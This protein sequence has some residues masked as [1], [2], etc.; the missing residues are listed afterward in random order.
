MGKIKQF[1][2]SPQN[3]PQIKAVVVGLGLLIATF[4]ATLLTGWL[5][6]RKIAS[7]E[8]R[9]PLIF[10]AIKNDI[11]IAESGDDI[12]SWQ[13]VGPNEQSVCD[14]TLFDNFLGVGKTFE[15]GQQVRLEYGRDFGKHYCFRAVNSEGVPGYGPHHVQELER[16]SIG[17]TQTASKLKARL[18]R[19]SADQGF[20]ES[21]W[22]HVVLEDAS[23]SCA[24]AAFA[25]ESQ[26]IAGATAELLA[27]NRELHYCFR[28]RKINS[29][30]Y[31]AKSVFGAPSQPA[32]IKSLRSGDNLYL[33]ADQPIKN[34]AVAV[35]DGSKQCGESYFSDQ[36]A[37]LSGYQVAIIHLHLEHKQAE[38]Y[39]V[40]AQNENGLFSYQT[41]LH[42]AGLA[43]E[44][45]PSLDAASDGLRLEASSESAVSSWQIIAVDSVSDCAPAAF[46]NQEQI[47]ARVSTLALNYP[48]DR[49]LVYCWQARQGQLT[50]YATYEIPIGTLMIVAKQELQ[51]IRAEALLRPL[52]DWHYVRRE[53]ATTTDASQHCSADDFGGEIFAGQSARLETDYLYCFRAEDGSGKTHYGIWQ[54][55]SQTS[56]EPQH[57]EISVILANDLKLTRLGQSILREARP[58]VHDNLDSLKRACPP[59]NRFSCYASDGRLHLLKAAQLDEEQ[60]GE[61]RQSL[62]R[63][64]RWN[65]LSAEQR[66][67]QNFELLLLYDSQ[68]AAFDSILPANFYLHRIYQSEFI[69]DF[70]D[71][72]LSQPNSWREFGGTDWRNYYLLFFRE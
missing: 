55:A 20:D 41:Y 70:H 15:E 19:D 11:L 64:V 33:L 34:W 8:A 69:G 21:S 12:K 39:C 35:L 4:S 54:A 14:Q 63:I 26:I 31:Q 27:A 3:R 72:L 7:Q 9:P 46:G 17:F 71:F 23:V 61:L 25:D 45:R 5:T 24:A 38:N 67:S 36:P 2:Q 37:I 50:A 1:I 62:A 47:L 18:E 43:I 48:V 51:V 40:R 28:I 56:A 58:V 22:Q 52:T 68:L 30:V 13:Y 65:F 53:Q 10:S 66:A 29:Y 49:R 44:I 32:I 60:R 42:S 57:E 59:A 6:G 16:P